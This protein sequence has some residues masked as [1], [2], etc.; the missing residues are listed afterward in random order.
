MI[1]RFDESSDLRFNLLEQ[2]FEPGDLF[3]CTGVEYV[4]AGV[5]VDKVLIDLD[6]GLEQ[7]SEVHLDQQLKTCELFISA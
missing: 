3:P 1:S 4:V 5:L 2:L 6:G 7:V